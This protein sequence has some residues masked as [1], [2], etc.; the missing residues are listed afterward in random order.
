MTSKL[1]EKYLVLKL[2]HSIHDAHIPIIFSTNYILFK[3]I[4]FWLFYQ[5]LH[6][7][8]LLDKKYYID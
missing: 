7:G 2:G 8:N 3:Q 6:S 4:S 5:K 1:Y